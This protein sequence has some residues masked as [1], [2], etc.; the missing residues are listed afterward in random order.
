MYMP[1]CGAGNANRLMVSQIDPLRFIW[2]RFTVD[3]HSIIFVDFSA[4]TGY[5]TI[6]TNLTLLDIFVGFTARTYAGITDKFI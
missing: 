5:Y 1:L 6:Y 4:H 2:Q 3:Q